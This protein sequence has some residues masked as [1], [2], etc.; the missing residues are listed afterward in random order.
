MH[1]YMREEWKYFILMIKSQNVRDCIEDYISTKQ[2]MQKWDELVHRIT[3]FISNNAILV[4]SNNV[5]ME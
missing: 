3:F 2:P 4:K 1:Q 5:K